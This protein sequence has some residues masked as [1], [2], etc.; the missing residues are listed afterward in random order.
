MRGS[1]IVCQKTFEGI[2]ATI[3]KERV[4][5]LL[6]FTK[7]FEVQIDALNFAIDGVL[8]QEGHPIAFENR[9]LNKA[10]HR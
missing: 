1:R 5:A 2:K 7:I 10:K 6:Y 8:M 9:K 4:L 3:T